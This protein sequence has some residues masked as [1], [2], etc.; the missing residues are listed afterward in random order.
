[1]PGWLPILLGFLTAVG[2]ASTDMYLP[3]FPAIETSLHGAPGSAQ[4][5]LATWFAGLAVGQL[6]QGTLADRFGRRAPLIAGMVLYTV[7]AAAS[8]LAPSIFWLSVLRALS[9]I[10]ASAGMV[11]PR[12]VV[13]DIAEGHAAAILMS[14][15]M[16]VMGVAPILAPTLGGV[17]LGFASWRTL[18]WLLT[19]YGAL[20]VVL[21]AW[22][23]PETLPPVR[24]TRLAAGEQCARYLYILREPVFASHACIMGAGAF[25]MFAY[26][27]GAS[28]VFIDG[29]GVSP[30][31][32][33]MIFGLCA[34]GLIGGAQVNARILGRFG[35]A[36]VLGATVRVL[37]MA[38]LILAAIALARF[39]SP[40]PIIPPLFCAI[41]CFGFLNPNTTVGALTRHA[42][43]AGAASALL[44]T[45]QF[46]CGAISGLAVGFLTDG[47]ARGM[48]GLML[49]GALATLA[50]DLWRRRVLA[51][52]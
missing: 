16:L 8:A 44:G 28:P 17:I 36:A 29:F 48:A 26:I 27:G 15:L 21:V 9:A 38:C 7:T 19:G 41:A 33:G 50:A 25:A 49:I 51:V 45:V 40:L 32:F 39:A 3:A 22:L 11:I 35:F 47:T 1:M 37:L 6:T 24:R 12:A 14:R 42:A 18:F 43:H 5:T 2:A 52:N 13:R 20:C 34:C 10:G 30:T 46:T 23:L 31:R 4:I